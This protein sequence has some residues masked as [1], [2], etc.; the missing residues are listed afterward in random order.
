VRQQALRERSDDANK[1][2]DHAEKGTA[3]ADKGTANGNKGTDNANKGT[4]NANKGAAN[5]NK[6]AANADKGGSRYF[7]NDRML[8]LER[9][10]RLESGYDDA[11]RGARPRGHATRNP[12]RKNST[13]T[14]GTPMPA[15]QASM[16]VHE[17]GTVGVGLRGKAL[18]G[19][20]A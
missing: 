14:C 16:L 6:G 17:L 3:N 7:G 19:S 9:R 5:A 11:L 8:L 18:S 20:S 12:L 1:G 15:T 4:A 10:I 2:A 13:Q